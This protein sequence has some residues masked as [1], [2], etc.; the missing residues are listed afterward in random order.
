V[1]QLLAVAALVV[2]TTTAA[3][4]DP[5]GDVVNAIMAFGKLSSYHV[6]ATIGKDHEISGDVVNP[7][8]MHVSA[9]PA[10]MIVIDKTTYV[11]M[12]S[13]WREFTLPGIDRMF[14]PLTYTQRLAAHRADVTVTDLGPKVVAGEPLHAYAV[15]STAVD[16]PATLYLDPSGTLT[17]VEVA[18]A[19][20]DIDAITFSNFNGP[21]SIVAPI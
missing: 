18:G 9:G 11:K 17:R 12:G 13:T 1:K 4:A 6:E 10:E 19:S 3:F 5:Q 20:G 8:R 14:S 7:G 21:I 2:A 16:K 15:K